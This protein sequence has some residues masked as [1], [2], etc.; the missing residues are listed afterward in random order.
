MAN[1]LL[2]PWT[3]NYGGVPPFAHVK[4]ADFV[5]AF[6]AAMDEARREL[7]VIVEN[8]EPPTF[9][10]TVLALENSGRTIDALESVY[11]VWSGTMNDAE[12]Q[13]VERALAPKLAAFS[14]EVMTDAALFARIAA[15]YEGP[16]LAKL[17]LW[18]QRLAWRYYNR[19]VRAG[20]KLTGEAKKRVGE[21]NQRLAT[22][23]T[24]FSQNIL[25]DEDTLVSMKDA[26]YEGLPDG[27]KEAFQRAGGVA[28][29]RSAVEPFLTYSTRED[30][31]EKVFTAFV[32]RGDNHDHHDNAAI[33]KEILSLRAERATLLGYET[34]AHWRL[35]ESMAKTPDRAMELMEA[36]WKPAVA[37]AREEI[38]DMNQLAGHPIQPWDY[39]YYAEKVRKQKYDLD[40][41]EI[42]PYLQLEKLREGMFWVAGE[43][44]GFEFT[45]VTDLEVYHP[46]V[47]VWKVEDRATKRHIGLWYFDPYARAGKQSG[48]WMASYRRQESFRGAVTSIVSNNAN[49][50][51][52]AEGT[53]V[54]ISWTDAVTLFHEFGHALHGLS[55]AVAY[56]SMSGTSVPRDY[57]EFPSQLLEHWL[58]TPEVL[59]RFALHHE[60]GEPLPPEL[61][62]KIE[63]AK[64]F[65]QGFGTVEYL[66][67]ALVD[68]KLHLTPPDTIDP[69]EFEKQTLAE[70]GMPPEIVM[71]HRT[72]QFAH[73]FSGDA[74][75]AGYYSYL[76]ADTL[77]AD[78]F[79]AFTAAKGAYDKA[80]AER[81]RTYVLSAG[82]TVDPAVGYRAFRGRD[83]DTSAL[84]RKRGFAPTP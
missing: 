60:T 39:R 64:T 3:G 35:E 51:K 25:A 22:L 36:V 38:A 66:S 34:H 59:G 26:D 46:D 5:P 41:N 24:T 29:T 4:V 40:E 72:P 68:M 17:S 12:F 79:E 81:L 32:S 69:G 15:V 83:P 53:P 37:R 19:R 78:A 9:E 55:S 18:E 23:F 50:V 54:L 75:S 44:L 21:I 47:R 76:W 33:I 31:R 52:G 13:D 70:F 65:N 56:P 63:N 7:R 62:A 2:T 20:A 43:L 11:G 73:I 61:V 77:T 42:T 1:P 58:P 10:N 67:A 49:F 27:A 16:E 80:V 28:N 14:D 82:D 48:A 84:M 8:S 6:D 45:A 30:L 71:R 74:Y 57:V